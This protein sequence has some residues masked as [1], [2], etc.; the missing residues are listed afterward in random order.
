MTTEKETFDERFE[1]GDPRYGPT[2]KFLEQTENARQ[3]E[4]A[5]SG[6]QREDR[7]NLE[8]EIRACSQGNGDDRVPAKCL[9]RDTC[10]M[11]SPGCGQSTPSVCLV[12]CGIRR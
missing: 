11:R 2:R 10:P 8:A 4:D 9:H 7:L 1:R 3:E 5:E 6:K 12:L